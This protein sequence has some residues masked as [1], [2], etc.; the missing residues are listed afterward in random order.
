M[1]V[2]LGPCVLVYVTVGACVLMYVTL[3][4]CVF[5]ACYTWALCAYAYIH[6]LKTWLKASFMSSGASFKIP[7]FLWLHGFCCGTLHCLW[8][9]RLLRW[10]AIDWVA[11]KP[12]EFIF[13][14][15][16]WR[17]FW[18]KNLRVRACS[19][20]LH[21]GHLV[22]K[23]KVS[24][25]C[26]IQVV[27]PLRR[28]PWSLC[29]IPFHWGYVSFFKFFLLLFVFSVRT[30]MPVLAEARGFRA[31]PSAQTTHGWGPTPVRAGS[32]TQVFHTSR[33]W[34]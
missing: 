16:G 20:D 2:T 3:G 1:Y 18:I 6:F 34:F 14:S 28:T 24:G 31:T 11:Y 33:T 22:G 23:N 17:R 12:Q 32:Q 27:I 9:Q 26:C 29:F 5:C 7:I 25:V 4:P 15:V 21:W 30:G 10:S 19:L 8:P 13:H